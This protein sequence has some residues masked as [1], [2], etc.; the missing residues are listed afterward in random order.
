MHYCNAFARLTGE[1]EAKQPKFISYKWFFHSLSM[2]RSNLGHKYVLRVAAQLL[3]FPPLGR[4]G[5]RSAELVHNIILH[6]AA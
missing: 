1:N 3:L 4:S 6:L 2:T 5:A